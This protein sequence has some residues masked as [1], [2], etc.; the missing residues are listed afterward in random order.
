MNY[1][2]ESTN[3]SDSD[4]WLLRHDAI[5]LLRTLINKVFNFLFPAERNVHLSKM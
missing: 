2:N 5:A 1:A 4:P 3:P